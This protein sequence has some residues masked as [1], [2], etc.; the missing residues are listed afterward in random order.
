MAKMKKL[1]DYQWHKADVKFNVN[2]KSIKFSV[3]HNLEDN[4]GMSFNAALDSWLAR[5]NKHTDKSLCKYIRS[6]GEEFIA[7]TEKEYEELSN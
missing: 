2:N 7:F 6:K 3:I 1:G 5:T 4:F